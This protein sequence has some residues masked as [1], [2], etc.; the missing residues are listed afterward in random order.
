MKISSYVLV[1]S[2]AISS[3]FV[4]PICGSIFQKHHY[5]IHLVNNLSSN[6][7]ML[8]HCKSKDDDLGVHNIPVGQQYDMDIV[9]NIWGGTLFWCY[10]ASDNNSHASFDAFKDRAELTDFCDSPFTK[11]TTCVWNV[12]DDGIYFV[13]YLAGGL[14]ELRFKW[15]EGRL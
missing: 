3:L 14:E 5:Y 13:D 4:E 1:F 7:V 12:K 11:H 10:V 8:V 15:Q 2:L 9:P 6:K